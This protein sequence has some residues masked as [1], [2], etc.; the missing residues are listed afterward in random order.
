MSD[1]NPYKVP[2]S[3]GRAMTA[4]GQVLETFDE[5]GRLKVSVDIADGSVT[6]QKLA[7]EVIELIN[8]RKFTPLSGSDND[9]DKMTNTGIYFNNG[10]YGL[11]NA[12]RSNYGW[13]LLVSHGVSNGHPRGAQLY[14]DHDGF[15]WRGFDGNSFTPWQTCIVKNAV[16]VVE[17][18]E[19]PSSAT[20]EQVATAF[21]LLLAALKGN[22]GGD[23]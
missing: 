20:A 23:A 10:G 13:M 22:G 5:E 14:F 15:D 4:D 1:P 11:Q 3:N 9:A 21:N 19:D 2:L 16:D 17:P 7:A 12:P 18:I 6:T 8:E